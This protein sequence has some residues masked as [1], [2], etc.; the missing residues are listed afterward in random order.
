MRPSA[1]TATLVCK[2][3]TPDLGCEE[4][5]LFDDPPTAYIWFSEDMFDDD[6][7]DDDDDATTTDA[8][9]SDDM[10]DDDALSDGLTIIKLSAATTPA[11]KKRCFIIPIMCFILFIIYI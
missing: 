5:R 3:P 9:F 8:W 7:D 6:D 4:S 10:F 11:K 1:P 2:K